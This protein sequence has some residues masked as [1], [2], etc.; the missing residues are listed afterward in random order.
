MCVGS[1][2]GLFT[3]AWQISSL[4]YIVSLLA[5]IVAV[6][7]DPYSSQPASRYRF[8]LLSNLSGAES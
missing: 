8:T 2:A 6:Y 4:P 7:G 5:D 1:G 3:I